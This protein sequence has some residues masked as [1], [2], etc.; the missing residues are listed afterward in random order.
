V[1]DPNPEIR[2]WSEDDL[3]RARNGDV[4][5]ATLLLNKGTYSPNELA[6]YYHLP[7]HTYVASLAAVAWTIDTIDDYAPE[8]LAA[9][10]ASAVRFA[11]AKWDGILRLEEKRT[12]ITY[13]V[14][15]LHPERGPFA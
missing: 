5:L 4:W 3:L 13:R 11:H 2:L 8:F 12:R 15:D 14:I 6:A 7:Q 10:D 9:D 1:T